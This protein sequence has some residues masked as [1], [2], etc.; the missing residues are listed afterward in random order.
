MKKAVLKVVSIMTVLLLMSGMMINVLADANSQGY[1][2]VKFGT[3]YYQ[4]VDFNTALGIINGVGNGRF[5][6]SACINRAMAI[7]MLY[8]V[9]GSPDVSDSVNPFVDVNSG[10]YYDNAVKWGVSNDIVRGVSKEIFAPDQPVTREQLACFIIRYAESKQADFLENE[11]YAERLFLD[12]ESTSAYALD[13]MKKMISSGLYQGNE[14]GMMCPK[15]TASRAE[16]A[17]VFCRMALLLQKLPAA[18]KMIIGNSGQTISLNGEDTSWFFQALTENA[19]WKV[20]EPLDFTPDYRLELW[21]TE[22]QFSKDLNVHG[23]NCITPDGTIHGMLYSFQSPEKEMNVLLGKIES[24]I[25]DNTE[26]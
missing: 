15:A 2:D 22:F 24:I 13:A 9:E 3:W 20:V 5:A 16:I 7:T 11:I 4:A 18:G 17:V 12:E 19:A 14:D 23:Y 8:R 10:C 1:S 21:G 26:D 6:P 25:K